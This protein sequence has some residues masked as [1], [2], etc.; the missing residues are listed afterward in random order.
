MLSN[1]STSNSDEQPTKS[2]EQYLKFETDVQTVFNELEDYYKPRALSFH[3][4]VPRSIGFTR[5]QIITLIGAVAPILLSVFIVLRTRRTNYWFYGLVI[6]SS[7]WMLLYLVVTLYDTWKDERESTKRRVALLKEAAKG[8]MLIIGKLRNIADQRALKFVELQFRYEIDKLDARG[9]FFVSFLKNFGPALIAL[10]FL[11]GITD[12]TASS[13][14]S[15]IS[16]ISVPA[17]FL[18]AYGAIAV[19]ILAVLEPAYQPPLIRLKK[20]V[21]LL[22]QAQ[23]PD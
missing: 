3:D 14:P 21:S 22:E 1:H 18:A 15:D 17:L 10:G 16:S 7:L 23:A 20:G 12:A 11:L 8:D 5:W 6:F 2:K 13:S 19:I 4:L 9:K